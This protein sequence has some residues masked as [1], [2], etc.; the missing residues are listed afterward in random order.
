MMRKR[1]I[2]TLILALCAGACGILDPHDLPP[3]VEIVQPTDGS[4]VTVGDLVEIV[5]EASDQDGT[6]RRVEFRID[7]QAM[8]RVEAGPYSWTWD[9]S[10][11]TSLSHTITVIARDESGMEALDSVATQVRWVYSPPETVDDGWET[12]SLTEVGI[13]PAPLEEL[14]NRLRDSQGHLVHSILILRHGKLA[15]EKYFSG[16]AHPTW[17]E[18][19]VA[20]DRQTPHVLSSVT[21]S[22][23]ATLLG[24]ALDQ[25]IIASVN[26]KVFDFFPHLSDLN[27]GGKDDI[28]L[29]H[30]VNM[31][32]G[33]EW[34]ESSETLGQAGNDL[35]D[36]MVLAFTTDEDPVRF[37]LSKPVEAAPG[38]VFN[39]SGGLTNVLGNAI[40]RA[41]GLRL[42][43]YAEAHLFEPTGIETVWWLLLQEDFVYA[44]GDIALLP[45]DMAKFG[46]MY[47]Q[48]GVWEGQ[49]IVPSAWVETS[50]TSRF[51]FAPTSGWVRAAGFDGYGYGWWQKVD[52]YGEGAFAASGWGGQEIL[53][54]PEHDMVVVFTGG[55]YWENAL[56]TPHEMMIQAVL[57]AI[58][59]SLSAHRAGG[60]ANP[61]APR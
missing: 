51:T 46:Q 34:N 1:A 58:G 5:V 44:S 37:V 11:Q 38:Q 4:V 39:Y 22:F 41:A 2:S 52:A 3:E 23:T 40:Q 33:L 50:A 45:R 60:R 47:L 12:V 7:G 49:Q 19:P 61:A 29:D 48:E 15:F 26:E 18:Y 6:L 9:T 53:I 21:K 17:G 36:M 20:F 14:I 43:R 25:G 16:R 56:L 24:I 13:D 28:T 35:T 32:A 42:D 55:A 54:L 10:G 31:C 57:P 59:P 27:T 8:A 30:L